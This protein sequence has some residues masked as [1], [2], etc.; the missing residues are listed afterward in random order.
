MS[1]SD[2]PEPGENKSP[3]RRTGK[4]MIGGLAL[5]LVAVALLI[6]GIQAI[7]DPTAVIAGSSSSPRSPDT[8][9]EAKIGGL[10]LCFF[11]ITVLGFGIGLFTSKT[12]PKTR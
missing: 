8:D 1:A 5:I 12:S 6:C 10:L 3:P 7:V 4:R 11:G 2:V 9:T